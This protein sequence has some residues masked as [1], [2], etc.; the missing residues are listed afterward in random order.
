MT[1]QIVSAKEWNAAREKL[2]VKE[3]AQSRA[4]DALAAERRRLRRQ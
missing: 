2:L 1:S 4:R 3:K